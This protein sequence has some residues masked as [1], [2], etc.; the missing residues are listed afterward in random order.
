MR[1]YFD[2][3]ILE[4]NNDK[5]I[6]GKRT[7][8]KDFKSWFREFNEGKVYPKNTKLYEF[9]ESKLGKEKF[10]SKGWKGIVF[11]RENENDNDNDSDSDRNNHN[12]LDV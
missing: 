8:W 3:R 7:V 1:E 2:A 5:D 4:T 10:S 12:D 9:L 6:I 11:K